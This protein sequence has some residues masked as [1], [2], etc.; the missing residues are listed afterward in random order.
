MAISF[1]TTHSPVIGSEEKLEKGLSVITAPN[2][3]PMTFT[4]TRTYLLGANN[5]IIID[6]GPDVDSHFC[7]IM[8]FLLGKKLTHILL[9]HS[10]VDHSPLSRR[11]KKETGATIIGFGSADEARTDFMNK[12][13]STIDLGGEEGIDADLV[14]DEKVIDGQTLKLNGSVFEI[15]H[16]PGHLSNHICIAWNVKNIIFSGDHLMG[17]ATTLISPPDG[18]LGSFIKSLEKLALRKEEKYYPGHGKPINHPLAM[19][20]AQLAHRRKRE[21]QILSSLEKSAKNP[22]EIV[23]EIY[24]DINPLLKKAALRN[25]LAHLIDLYERN[26]ICVNNFSID[27]QFE[28]S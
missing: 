25:V 15:I 5:V 4:G 13:S 11:L 10:H 24:N 2:A 9:T 16:T 26:A 17:W 19:V 18:D 12:L 21:K 8:N 27:A 7:A 20:K 28:I 22:A 23:N 3:S 1:D 6:P 14:L